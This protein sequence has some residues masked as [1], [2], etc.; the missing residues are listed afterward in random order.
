LVVL[1]KLSKL[2]AADAPQRRGIDAVEMPPHQFR[3]G[4][5]GAGARVPAEQFGVIGHA[6]PYGT[7][8]RQNRT[9]N[10]PVPS[11]ATVKT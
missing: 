11:R 10:F 3:E 9:K 1:I 5:F 2:A 6:L 7:R 8:H 4:V